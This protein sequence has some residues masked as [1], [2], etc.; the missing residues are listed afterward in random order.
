[1]RVVRVF[2]AFTTL[3]PFYR[4]REVIRFHEL[5]LA[6][7]SGQYVCHSAPRNGSRQD[8]FE[9]YERKHV[10][11]VRSRVWGYSDSC[12]Q[13][14]VLNLLWL[15]TYQ[16]KPVIDQLWIQERDRC[17]RACRKFCERAFWFIGLLRLVEIVLPKR[18]LPKET[19]R[20]RTFLD[21]T[22]QDVVSR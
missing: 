16:V 21:T 9:Q 10:D 11:D 18:V 4:H 19:V 1:M 15:K 2:C 7:R 3:A 8:A 14:R 5:I 13:V 17:K 12:G 22:W 6:A 20:V